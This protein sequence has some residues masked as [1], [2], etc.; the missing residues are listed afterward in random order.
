[1]VEIKEA[2]VT[3]NPSVKLNENVNENS[4]NLNGDYCGIEQEPLLNQQHPSY[5][6]NTADIQL[7][8]Q[9]P[10]QS[11]NLQTDQVDSAAH[12]TDYFYVKKP[13]NY[14]NVDQCNNL[15]TTHPSN[16]KSES[17][18]SLNNQVDQ[19][20][21]SVGGGDGGY[22]PAGFR[23]SLA[24]SLISENLNTIDA[25]PLTLNYQ[26]YHLPR[27]PQCFI[28]TNNRTENMDHHRN[29]YVMCPM[30]LQHSIN[31]PD[32][33]YQRTM[34]GIYTKDQTWPSRIAISSSKLIQQI[35]PP[36]YT[37]AKAFT[38]LTP[39]DLMLYE[40]FRNKTLSNADE[41]HTSHDNNENGIQRRSL[42]GI[43]SNLNEETIVDDANVD[44]SSDDDQNHGSLQNFSTRNETDTSNVTKTLPCG[45]PWMFGVHKNRKVIQLNVPKEPEIGFKITELQNQGIFVDDIVSSSAASRF[46][47]KMDKILDIDGVDC[48]RI[49]L[50]EACTVLSNSGPI[51]NIM[52]SRI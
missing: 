49:S 25:D 22:L 12:A 28:T 50:K 34:D 48:T 20:Y 6:H 32:Q 13:T 39:N 43:D 31:Q 7:L 26:S 42:N 36:P 5:T 3:A 46:L 21:S 8:Q 27:S 38:K 15:Y 2:L 10:R 17:T 19:R 23:T 37:Y 45:K 24:N 11:P 47:K 9:P 14:E 33:H 41:T 1:M 35:E 30:Q 40:S 44:K 18:L 51:L 29:G 16:S 4:D 52:I